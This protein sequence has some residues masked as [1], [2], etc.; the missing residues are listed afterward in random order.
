MFPEYYGGEKDYTIVKAVMMELLDDDV[1][2][3]FMDKLPEVKRLL[4][5][6]A[7]ATMHNDPAVTDL[8]EVMICYP[9]MTAMEHYRVA[10]ELL[11][12]GVPMLPRL[13][14]ELAHSR[15]GIDIHP[16]ATIGEYF[17]ID[18][19]T[20]VVIGATAVIGNHVMLYQ[21]V[22]LGAKS[23]KYDAAGHPIDEPRHPIIEDN[24]TIYSNASILGR[25]RIG[26]DTI[27]GGN[28]WLT[29]DVPPGSRILQGKVVSQPLFSDGAGI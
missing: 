5:G 29:H 24:V 28:V 15:T 19:G 2:K 20:G 23:F 16:A 7:E 27:I 14:T 22:T 13:I 1:I 26:H 4:L 21:G 25:I 18:H 11:K 6:D 8:G 9:V 12:L 17:S 3:A 10:H